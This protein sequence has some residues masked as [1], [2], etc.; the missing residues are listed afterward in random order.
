[1]D[2]SCNPYLAFSAITMATLDGILNKIH[3]GEPLDKDIY[4]LPPEE[5]KKVPK[6]PGSLGEALEALE[7]DHAFLLKGNVFTEDV[8][9]YWV[10]YKRENEIAEV[11]SRPTPHEFYLYF[12]A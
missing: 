7:D 8:I 6:V 12:D 2:P 1:P 4:D 11:D 9:R 5:L 3:P 10:D